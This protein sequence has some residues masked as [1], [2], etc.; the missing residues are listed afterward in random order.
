[1]RALFL[2]LILVDGTAISTWSYKPR[3]GLV[4]SIYWSGPGNRTH[5]LPAVKTSN[6]PAEPILLW[7]HNESVTLFLYHKDLESW[8]WQTANVRFKL[9]I[10]QSKI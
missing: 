7:T 3:E 2:P 5:D 10:S 1:M 6:L 8:L 4:P 9:T